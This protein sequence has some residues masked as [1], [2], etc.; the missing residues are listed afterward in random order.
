MVFICIKN[1]DES[2]TRGLN[3][4]ACWLTIFHC[5]IGLWSSIGSL[6]WF[7]GVMLIY[8]SCHPKDC[9]I[10]VFC[11]MAKIFSEIFLIS[12]INYSLSK[13]EQFSVFG[14]FGLDRPL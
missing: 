3:Q 7:C 8:G 5:Y 9:N 11:S 1:S 10:I 14:K 12:C 6:D 4:G 2:T 13:G